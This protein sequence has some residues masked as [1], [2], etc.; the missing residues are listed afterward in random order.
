MPSAPCPPSH[1]P[2][3]LLA[4]IWLGGCGAAP[5]KSDAEAA[6]SA[7]AQSEDSGA[8]AVTDADGDGVDLP[9]DCND[10]DP[11]VF[12][13]AVEICN[14]IDDNCDGDTDE[15]VKQVFYTDADGDGFGNADLSLEACSAPEGTVGDGTDCDDTDPAISPDAEEICNELDDDCDGDIDEDGGETIYA[16]ADSD[17][18]GD[19]AISMTGCPGAGWVTE[20]GDCDDDD[21]QVN[22]GQP[23]DSCDGIDTDC[24]GDIDEDSKAGWSLLSVDTSAGSVFEI[25]PATA[26]TNAISAVSTRQGINSMD[27]SENGQSVVHTYTNDRLAIF[28]AC[29]GTAT[30]IG[31]HGMSGIGGIGFGPGGRLFGIGSTDLLYEFNPSTGVGSIVGPLGINV[32]TS[33]LAWDCTTQTMYGADGSGNRIFEVDLTTGAATNIQ[34]TTVPFGSVG[35]EFDRVSGNLY[36]STGSALYTIDPTNGSS[37]YIGGLAASNIDDLAWHPPCP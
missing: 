19:D 20:A 3:C 28:D 14:G 17:G 16:D 36:A 12:P 6:D 15:G 23:I 9:E 31:P 11:D 33:G 34:Q 10:T 2:L 27:V 32:S 18:W 13:G 8:P 25:D 1:A 7:P 5:P 30:D 35:L 22:P 4:L 26:A 29:T 21:P 37:T 24:D